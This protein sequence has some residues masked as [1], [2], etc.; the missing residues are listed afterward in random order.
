V[1]ERNHQL[2]GNSAT[3]ASSNDVADDDDEI[4]PLAAQISSNA[5]MTWPSGRRGFP[6]R[7]QDHVGPAAAVLQESAGHRLVVMLAGV[8]MEELPDAGT[9]EGLHHRRDLM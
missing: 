4:G 3:R 5:V 8:L 2:C 7:R 1:R 9:A 6:I